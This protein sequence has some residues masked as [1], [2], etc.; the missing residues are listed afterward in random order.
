M[1]AQAQPGTGL[2]N[3]QARLTA[4]FGPAARLQ[5]SEPSPCGLRAEILRPDG[6]HLRDVRPMPAA[7]DRSYVKRLDGEHTMATVDKRSMLN[8]IREDINKF[9]DEKQVDRVVMLWAAA[10]PAVPKL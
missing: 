8:A 5:M 9:R 4:F 6:V 2:T 10:F 7:F 1:H 3:L